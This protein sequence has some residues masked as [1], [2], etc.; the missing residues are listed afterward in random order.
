MFIPHLRCLAYALAFIIST[1]SNAKDLSC[2]QIYA[3]QMKG[4]I[5]HP[6]QQCLDWSKNPGAIL[7]RYPDNTF[8]MNPYS[9][10][11]WRSRNEIQAFKK[12]NPP[13]FEKIKSDT[14]DLQV[15]NNENESNSE[16]V[17]KIFTA[18]K[19]LYIE[20]IAAGKSKNEWSPIQRELI[21]NYQQLHLLPFEPASAD[22]VESCSGFDPNMAYHGA[23]MAIRYCPAAMNLPASA[24]IQPLAHELAHASD[25]C[26]LRVYEI[27]SNKKMTAS[28][29]KSCAGFEASKILR[30]A[31]RDHEKGFINSWTAAP[32][33]NAAVKKLYQCGV[34]KKPRFDFD[35][36]LTG[37][38]FQK[39]R[40]AASYEYQGLIEVKN[41]PFTIE[42]DQNRCRSISME[43]FADNLGAVVMNRFLKL[44]PEFLTPDPTNTLLFNL[45]AEN[46]RKLNIRSYGLFEYP[47]TN[48]RLATYMQAPEVQ[49]AL[50][51]KGWAQKPHVNLTEYFNDHLQLTQILP[52]DSQK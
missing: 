34:L 40:D 52:R 49:N 7:K 9:P 10:A 48:E 2:E 6:G 25:P 26:L 20:Q 15:F 4:D 33:R 38:P 8:L 24:A 51:C 31:R 46:C 42:R 44:Y 32:Q 43:S 1:N 19:N 27:D 12:Y 17:Q 3:S 22:Y 47:R 23:E 45:S 35:Q 28:E 39:I 11:V 37:Y 5:G 36:S 18:L 30:E 16:R 21:A 14:R 29:I 13:V 50:G 41:S